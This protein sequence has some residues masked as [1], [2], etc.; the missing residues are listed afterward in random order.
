MGMFSWWHLQTCAHRWL[1]SACAS[2][3]SD[4]SLR[5]PHEETFHPWLSRMRP[6]SIL[7]K[8][9]E[10]E[11]W[12]ESSL[13]THICRYMY[14]FWRCA[15]YVC[16]V[17][18]VRGLLPDCSRCSFG[19]C[20]RA[21]LGKTSRLLCTTSG[22]SKMTSKGSTIR[23]NCRTYSMYSVRQSCANSVDPDQTPQNAASDQGLHCCHS[24]SNFKHIQK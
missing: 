18:Q 21:V 19:L 13:D 22:R 8:L 3:L 4:E 10:C 7:I 17:C 12:S 9:R 14:V 1:K 24:S 15:V 6:V 11:G 5:F 16:F 20:I 23:S 2:A